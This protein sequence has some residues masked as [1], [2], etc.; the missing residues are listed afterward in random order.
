MESCVKR[1]DVIFME[2][3]HREAVRMYLDL[4]REGDADA[5][6]NYGF[7]RLFGLGCER[8]FAEAKSFFTFAM[9]RVPEAEYNLA[10]MY[11]QT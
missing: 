11:L 9:A 6:F 7:C 2:G 4:A 8:D 1:A 5:A 10:V 3:R